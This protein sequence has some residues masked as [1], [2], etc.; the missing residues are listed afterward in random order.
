MVKWQGWYVG[1]VWNRDGR[2]PEEKFRPSTALSDTPSWMTFWHVSELEEMDKNL[3]FPIGKVPK[4]EGGWTKVRPPRG[5][6]LVGM[7]SSLE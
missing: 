4:F 5:P 2:H 1:Q 7:P 6:V 3:W